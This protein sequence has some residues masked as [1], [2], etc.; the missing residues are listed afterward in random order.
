MLPQPRPPIF[1]FS[2]ARLF[3]WVTLREVIQGSFRYRLLGQSASIAYPAL[4]ALLL[5]SLALLLATGLM[6]SGWQ[7][8]LVRPLSQVLPLSPLSEFEA[9]T[10]RLAP[11]QQRR[12]LVLFG[13]LAWGVA[14]AAMQGLMRGFD[15]IHQIPVRQRRS[16]WRSRLIA[17]ALVLLLTLAAALLLSL[18]YASSGAIAQAQQ[19]GASFDLWAATLRRLLYWLLAWTIMVATFIGLYRLGPSRLPP[20]LPLLP[21]ALLPASTWVVSLALWQRCES[22]LQRYQATFGTVGLLI[23]LMIWVYGALLMV[24]VGDQINIS[25]ARQRALR[26]PQQTRVSATPPSFDSFTIRRRND[27]FP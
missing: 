1:S 3:D 8:G 11:E 4:L 25:V 20:G 22:L 5:A 13:L 23:V 6:P 14:A 7:Q 21:G 15:L 24:L 27:R 10:G 17:L 16:L 18:A 19:V 12:S 2:L 26:P 9:W